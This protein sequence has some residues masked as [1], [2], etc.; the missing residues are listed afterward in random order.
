VK[1]AAIELLQLVHSFAE[2]IRSIPDTD[3]SRKPLPGK[4]SRQE[5]LGHLIDSAQTNLRRFVC[6][7]YEPAPPTIVYN[8]DQW[9]AIQGYQEA[10]KED[11]VLLWK[12]LNERI[13]HTL[14]S[15]PAEHYART[16][17]TGLETSELHTLEW[18]AADYVRHLKHHLNQIVPG[19]LDTKHP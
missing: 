17:N 8:Q 7:Q 4:W 16:C 1:P 5:I 18:L 12:L 3:F 19:S 15:M 6:A 13:A 9:V 11:L 2:L 10:A 14:L